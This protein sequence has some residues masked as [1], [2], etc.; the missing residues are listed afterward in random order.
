MNDAMTAIGLDETFQFS[1]NRGVACFN[2]CCRDL[3]QFLTPYDI[4]RLKNALGMTSTEFLEKYT[5]QHTGPESGL[6]VI[7]IKPA[8]QRELV[9]PF[10]TPDGCRVYADRP[11][12]CRTY[13]LARLVSR[14]RET[15][16]LTE[17][18]AVIHESHCRGFEQNQQMVVRDWIQSQ[19]LAVYNEM[20][21]LMMEI[22]SL[23]N[24]RKPGRLDLKE[25]RMFHMACY[26]LD[27]FRT[28]IFE[29]GLLE[30]MNLSAEQLASFKDDEILLRFG[31]KWIKETLFQ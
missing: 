6:P 26:D 7:T 20:N 17:H 8:D 22:I 4:L 21:D 1:C 29:K 18:W 5:L 24:Q 23:K 28:H 12:S 2:E 15:G 10:V 30:A 27:A 25:Q 11:G 14:S 3:N 9:C 13:P 31:L 16:R 19:E